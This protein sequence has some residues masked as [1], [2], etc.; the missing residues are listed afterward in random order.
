ME[1]VYSALLLHSAKKEVNETNIKKVLEGV[2]IKADE[3][4]TKV[5]VAALEGVN[6]DEVIKQAALPVATTATVKEEKKAE[7]KAKPQEEEKKAEEAVSGLA[8]LFG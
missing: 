1:Y 8:S 6:I 7:E 3:A 2:G 4:K 5:L